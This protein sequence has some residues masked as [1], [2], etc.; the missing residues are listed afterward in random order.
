[1]RISLPASNGVQSRHDVVAG[2]DYCA[3]DDIAKTGRA[4]PS[5]WFTHARSGVGLGVRAGADRPTISS[6]EEFKRVLLE[7]KSITISRS[8]APGS[9][10]HAMDTAFERLGISE[11]MG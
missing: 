1:M 4:G 5:S 10:R 11:L 8:T 7:A 9:P 3:N 2:P 6:P